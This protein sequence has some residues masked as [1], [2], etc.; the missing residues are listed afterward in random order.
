MNFVPQ[1]HGSAQNSK[2]EEIGPN[3]N[4]APLQLVNSASQPSSSVTTCSKAKRIM[5]VSNNH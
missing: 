1:L 5:R 2:I 3:E 4:P